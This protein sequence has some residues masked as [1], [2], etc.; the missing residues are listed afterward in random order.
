[1]VYKFAVQYLCEL[2][3]K[4]VK[5]YTEF[6]IEAF[7]SQTLCTFPSAI[8]RVVNLENNQTVWAN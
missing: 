6:A 8:I 2:G 5:F 7:V 1:M 4:Q 3:A